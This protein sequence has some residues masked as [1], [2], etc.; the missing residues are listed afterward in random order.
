MKRNLNKRGNG[1]GTI[2]YRE[3]LK[4]WVGQITL[5]VNSDGKQIRKTFYGNTRKEIKEKLDLLQME[6]QTEKDIGNTLSIVDIAE[7]IRELK[8]KTNSIK[9]STYIRIEESIN[10]MRKLLPYA[11]I[12]IQNV[13]R[14]IINS[15]SQVLV[16]YSQSVITK[17]WQQLQGAFNEA[18]IRNIVEKNPFELKGY[19]M[20]PKSNKATKKVDAL[21]VKEEERFINELNKGY[22][23]YTI[24]F[25]IAIYTG[26]R[27]SEILAL[28]GE[29]LDFENKKIHVRKT[30]SHV[31]KGRILLEKTT[32]TYAGMRDVP[33]LNVL[34]NKLIE[35]KMDK[36]KGFLFLKNGNFIHA[37]NFNARFQ[38][39]CKNAD[40]RVYKKKKSIKGG[41]KTKKIYEFNI[42]KSR[43][44]THMLRHTFATRCIENGV[45]PV[46][47][48][49]ILGHNDIQ[50]TLNTYTD[51]LNEFKE[52]EIEKI[53]NFF[54]K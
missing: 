39:L 9:R 11:N 41:R 42:T 31:D 15:Q 2:F 3:K 21:T 18:R 38:K 53:E 36:K 6:K 10:I 37:T 30:L 20:K 19:L 5:G 33:M 25:Y 4:K 49:K 13:T 46:V 34:Y 45:S 12:P 54:D 48:Q 28:E 27:I 8:Y 26:M 40:I 1:E 47:L 17:V 24:V 50:V 22:D 29:D 44:N 14:S 32:K 16:S 7:E 51:V 52:K 43:V 23:D 35:Y